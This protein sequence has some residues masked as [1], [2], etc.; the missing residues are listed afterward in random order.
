MVSPGGQTIFSKEGRAPA[1]GREGGLEIEK[2]ALERH[3]SCPRNF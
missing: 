3:A 1:R 2:N